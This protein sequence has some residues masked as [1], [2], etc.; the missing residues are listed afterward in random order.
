[1][2]KNLIFDFGKVLVDYDYFVILDKIFPS[3]E[4]AED[5]YHHLM[6]DKWNEHLDRETCPFEQTIYEM[7]QAMPQYAKEIQYFGDHYPEFVLG[8]MKGMRG[9]LTNLKKKGYNLYGLT[10]WSSR[11]HITMKQYPIFQLLDGQVISSE[12]HIVKPEQAIYECICQRFGL[13]PEE[14]V[15]ADDKPEN[16]TAAKAYGMQGIWFKDA[17]QYEKELLTLIAK[18]G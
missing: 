14:C 7:Q 5:F 17:A 10:N 2:I 13:K 9:L 3:H 8:E 11:V 1:M 18:L 16:I 15:F 4:Q 6:D 12:E